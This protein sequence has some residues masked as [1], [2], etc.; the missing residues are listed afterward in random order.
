[1]T[2]GQLNLCPLGFNQCPSDTIRLPAAG[3]LSNWRIVAHR[4]AKRSNLVAPHKDRHRQ[5]NA[6]ALRARHASRRY[7]AAN[8]ASHARLPMKTD[9]R[10]VRSLKIECTGDFSLNKIKPQIRL[11]GQWLERAGFTPGNRVEVRC[12]EPGILT[13]R[14]LVQAKA[15]S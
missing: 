3:R 6:R 2:T 10:Q 9:S 5:K 14:H 12:D 8:R 1:M 13:L 4:F 15:T 11:T 7:P